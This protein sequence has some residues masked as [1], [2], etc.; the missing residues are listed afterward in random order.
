MANIVSQD[1]GRAI[2]YDDDRDEF[3]ALTPGSAWLFVRKLKT[4]E[5]SKS[6]YYTCDINNLDSSVAVLDTCNRK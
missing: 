2:Q 4:E 6:P 1:A 5:R 3:L